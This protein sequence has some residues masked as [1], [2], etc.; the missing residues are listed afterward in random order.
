MEQNTLPTAPAGTG[1]LIVQ[2]TT[3]NT[4]I[5]LEGAFVRISQDSAERAAVLYELRS[6]ADGRTPRVTLSAPPRTA[7]LS[8]DGGNAF[9]SYNIEVSL[10]GYGSTAY[11][12]VPIFDGITS[13]QGADLIPIPQNGVPDRVGQG[14]PRLFDAKREYQ[15]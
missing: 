15:L 6:G 3:A 14:S 4:A 12:H 1:Y 9:A 7:S 8:P 10:E 5:P 13:I 11:Q 2:V